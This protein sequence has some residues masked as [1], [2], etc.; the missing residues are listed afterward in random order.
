MGMRDRWTHTT[1]TV[2][3]PVDVAR[4]RLTR[5]LTV[6]ARDGELRRGGD[7]EAWRWSSATRPPD[8][9][10]SARTIGSGPLRHGDLA[11]GLVVD[12]DVLLP[13]DALPN[14]RSPEGELFWQLDVK[15]DER[16]RDTHEIRRII[17]DAAP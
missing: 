16:G 3:N 13:G 11:T 2:L 7:V 8:H 10:H 1:R 12:F 9:G 4:R 6:T 15:S 14:C 17:V 5:G